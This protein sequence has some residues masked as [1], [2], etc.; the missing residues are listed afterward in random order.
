ML[1]V[2]H[3]II[4]L[5]LVRQRLGVRFASWWL[6]ALANVA[7]IV[8]LV[9]LAWLWPGIKRRVRGMVAP[10]GQRGATAVGA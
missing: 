7:L 8:A 5:T 2:I 4:A 3:Q 10:R 1:Y 6:Y 9:G